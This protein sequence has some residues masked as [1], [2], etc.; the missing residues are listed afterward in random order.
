MLLLRYFFQA[1]LD[2]IFEAGITISRVL[3]FAPKFAWVA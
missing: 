2:D 3:D 1:T